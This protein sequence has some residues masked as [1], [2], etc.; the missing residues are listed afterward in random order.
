MGAIL[1]T[2]LFLLIVGLRI[3]APDTLI[4][5]F[6]GTRSNILFSEGFFRK[7]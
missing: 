5:G 2:A 6:A 7:I 4:G 1:M 3:G